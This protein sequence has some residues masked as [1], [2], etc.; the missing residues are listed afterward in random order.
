MVC[1]LGQGVEK[2]DLPQFCSV[3]TT[4]L[5]NFGCQIPGFCKM[6]TGKRV[7]TFRRNLTYEEKIDSYSWGVEI[8]Y[9]G[10]YAWGTTDVDSQSRW[11]P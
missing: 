5:I 3:L 6:G 2:F 10:R 11:P 8:I 1:L 7:C 9:E 4:R